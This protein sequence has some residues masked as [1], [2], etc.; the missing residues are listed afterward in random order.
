VQG[1][2]KSIRAIPDAKAVVCPI[3]NQLDCLGGSHFRVEKDDR[4]LGICPVKHLQGLEPAAIEGMSGH[5]YAADGFSPERMGRL[6]QGRD[7][8]YLEFGGEIWKL[9]FDKEKG[10]GSEP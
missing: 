9:A 10:V 1:L 7:S 4:R 2:P 6:V 3:A 8:M 5:Q